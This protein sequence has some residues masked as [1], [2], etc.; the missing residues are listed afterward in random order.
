MSE[1]KAFPQTR[2]RFT[3]ASRAAAKISNRKR[4]EM[5][6]VVDTPE[7]FVVRLPISGLSFVWEIRRF[8]GFVLSR[9]QV[10][11]TDLSDA[12]SA[13]ERALSDMLLVSAS[14]V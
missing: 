2:C 10:V 14:S 8:G 3:D 9:S 7:V 4:M 1:L 11:F 5:R 12:R 13:G 6:G